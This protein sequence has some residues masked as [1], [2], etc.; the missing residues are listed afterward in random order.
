VELFELLDVPPVLGPA[1]GAEQEGCEDDSTVDFH[2]CFQ[3][4]TMFAPQPVLES[5]E[6]CTTTDYSS[7][8]VIIHCD[9]VRQVTSRQQNLLALVRIVSPAMTVAVADWFVGYE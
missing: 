4:Y 8:D 6:G 1:L 3:G 9:C 5:T 7:R 2:L